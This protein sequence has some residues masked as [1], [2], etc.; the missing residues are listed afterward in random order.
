GVGAGRLDAAAIELAPGRLAAAA[1]ALARAGARLRRARRRAIVA[2]LPTLP[3]ASCVVATRPEHERE[4]EERR[5]RGAK[6]G[7]HG[8]V[9]EQARQSAGHGF[10]NR[11]SVRNSSSVSASK[12]AWKSARS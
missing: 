2:A 7:M 12:K 4:R 3:A 1:A 10:A 8:W 6:V 11:R 5:G 9:S